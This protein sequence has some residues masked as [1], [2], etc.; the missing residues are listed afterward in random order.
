[1]TC[2]LKRTIP[3]KKIKIEKSL[4]QRH[5]YTEKLVSSCLP[6][7]AFSPVPGLVTFISI[8]VTHACAQN[9]RFDTEIFI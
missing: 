9:I 3:A 2:G 7:G 6:Q 4:Q 5:P 8:L 1:M